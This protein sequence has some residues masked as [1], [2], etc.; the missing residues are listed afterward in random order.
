MLLWSKA[1]SFGAIL[2]SIIDCVLGVITWLLVTKI[3]YGRVTLNTIGRNAP[4]LAGNLVSTFTGG[5]VHV[6]CSLFWPQN[7]DW[8]TTKKITMVEKDTTDLPGDE[9]EEEKLRKA[10][11][12]IIKWGLGFTL[13]IVV[14]WPALSLPGYCLK[15]FTFWAVVAVVIAMPVMESWS[16]IQYVLAGMFTNDRLMARMDKINAKLEMIMQVLPDAE[17]RHLL[18]QEK[19][20]KRKMD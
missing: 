4:M 6:I 5:V 12:W 20:R 19:A 11:Q 9:S 10:K 15:Y 18:E 17:R 3:E 16:T 14:L 2:G 7:Y 13:A 1:N 8:D